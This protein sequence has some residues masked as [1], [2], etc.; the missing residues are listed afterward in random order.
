MDNRA[1]A[2][3]TL[4]VTIDIPESPAK[5]F[6]WLIEEL[7]TSLGQAGMTFEPGQNGRVI[8]AGFEVGRVV[9]WIPGELIRIEWRPASWKPDLLTEVQLKLEPLADGATRAVLEQLGW[10][11][12]IESPD[13]LAGWFSSQVVTP[14][15]Y[16]A[17]PIGGGIWLTDRRARRPSGAQSRAVYRDPLYHYPNFYVLLELLSLSPDDY[18]LEVGC[19]GGAFLNMALQSGCRAAAVDHSLE[20]VQLAREVNREAVESGRLDVHL[21]NATALPFLDGVFTSAVMTGVLGFLAEPVVAL[22][23]IRRVLSPG[24]RLA[25]LGSDIKL[26]GTPAAP[27]PMASYLHFYTD[28]ELRQLALDAGF[29]PVEVVRRDLE[30]Y[31]RKAGVPEEALPLFAGEGTTFMLAR[32]G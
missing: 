5:V 22:A 8:Q 15:L 24:G 17:S 27:E 21:A 26:K 29:E 4:G 6:T 3:T 20:M 16:A 1:T 14:L 25:V 13:E 28:D 2:T 30:P 32:K 10:G 7:T 23:E 18:L 11:S 12:L 9:A 19:G 31:A